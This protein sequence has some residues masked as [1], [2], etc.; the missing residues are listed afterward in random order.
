MPDVPVVKLPAA[1]PLFP[2]PNVVLLPHALLP[3]HIFEVRYKKMTADVLRSHKQVAMALLKPGWEKGY[4]GRP[5]VEPVVCVGSILSHE[6][7]ADGCYNFLLRGHTRARVVREVGDEPYRQ[8]ELEPLVETD[9]DEGELRAARGSLVALFDRASYASLPGGA[10]MRQ[11]L[12]GGIS[13]SAVADLLAFNL[14]SD[15]EVALKQALLAETS[16]RRRVWRVLEALT[17]LQPAWQ[18]VPDDSSLN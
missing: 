1:V 8:A 4:Y 9:A 16:V 17:A 11:L 10:Q 6:R 7:L 2:L 3:L 13:T 18:N 5:A 12:A 15:D 14:L